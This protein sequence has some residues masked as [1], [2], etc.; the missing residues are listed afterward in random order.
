MFFLLRRSDPV[1]DFWRRFSAK[2]NAIATAME[3]RDERA[4]SRFMRELARAI[5]RIDERLCF[6]LC[7]N[8]HGE[9][10]FTVT[11]DGG[12]ELIPLVERVSRA[13]PAMKGWRIVALRQRKAFGQFPRLRL[14]EIEV[15][16][17]RI[18][19]IAHFGAAAIRV[20]LYF[21][22]PKH[23]PMDALRQI[24][25]LFLDSALGEYDALTSI[26]SINAH[27]GVNRSTQPF[28]TF[29]RAHDEWKAR[30]DSP[31]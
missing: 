6:E 20:H 16:A 15:G 31:A 19:W 14:G 28:E 7:K 23:V 1:A 13:A 3:A 4:V 9:F 2:A 26:A 30:R 17:E 25:L 24:S 12:R 10:E 22:L 8:A 5:R 21:D 11:P 27:H 29:A 18:G